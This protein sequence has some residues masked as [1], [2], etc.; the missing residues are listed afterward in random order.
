MSK[1]IVELHRKNEFNMLQYLMYECMLFNIPVRSKDIY[2][3]HAVPEFRGRKLGYNIYI[4]QVHTSGLQRNGKLIGFNMNVTS[5]RFNPTFHKIIEKSGLFNYKLIDIDFKKQ[6]YE[7]FCSTSTE[8]LY[9]WDR[10]KF[11]TT[12][13]Y[14]T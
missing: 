6:Y 8:I 5:Y 7:L 10:D 4:D 14:L 2:A 1:I 9:V 13:S 3:R 12:G 11:R